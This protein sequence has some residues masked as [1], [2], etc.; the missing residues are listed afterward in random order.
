MLQSMFTKLPDVLP[1][2]FFNIDWGERGIVIPVMISDKIMQFF[3][4]YKVF[5]P[6]L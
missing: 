6:E 2:K 5:C 3:D 1:A 4:R